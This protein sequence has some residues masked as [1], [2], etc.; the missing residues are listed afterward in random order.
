MPIVHCVST[1]IFCDN[2]KERL[3]VLL[4]KWFSPTRPKSAIR[5]E[6]S[7]FRRPNRMQG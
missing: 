3:L 5:K 7:H 2:D 6:S 1:R 4:V